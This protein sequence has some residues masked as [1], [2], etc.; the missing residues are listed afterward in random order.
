MPKIEITPSIADFFRTEIK[1]ISMEHQL[2]IQEMTEYYLV[3]LLSTHATPKE[4]PQ[5]QDVITLAELFGKAFSTDNPKVRYLNLK[6]LG[7]HALFVS[8]F[9]P[10]MLLKKSIDIEYYISMGEKAYA[11]LSSMPQQNVFSKAYYELSHHFEQIIHILSQL[12]SEAQLSN[13]QDL[14]RLY[15]R[16]LDSKDEHLRRLLQS[17]GIDLE[18]TGE[19]LI[20]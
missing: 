6:Q 10:D 2:K 7:D 3:Q 4:E 5:N 13:N 17:K 12:S 9:F 1:K 18:Q 11:H 8:G 20:H 14:L 16:W 15:E 19:R